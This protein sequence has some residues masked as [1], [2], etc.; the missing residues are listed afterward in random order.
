[1]KL[2]KKILATAMLLIGTASSAYAVNVTNGSTF[3]L[4]FTSTSFGGVLLDSIVTPVTTG[5]FSGLARAAVYDV[6]TGL[7]FYYQF[8]NDAASKHGIERLSTFNYADFTVWT[9]DAYQTN[10]AFGV[11]AAGTKAATTID[12]NI[13]GDVLGTNYLPAGLGKIEP[14]ENGYTVILRTNA[15]HYTT[16]NL[17]IIDGI[18]A[19]AP[20]FAPAVPE[21]ETYAM[22]I[23]G[24]GMLGFL[25][26]RKSAKN[27]G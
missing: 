26:R 20:A 10:A 4:P 6:G 23:A 1:M 24:L 21:P 11:F 12:R 22:M 27:L 18:S 25:A 5:V 16:G 15:H 13:Q 17:A 19:N 9:V 7:D 14:G 8:T 2:H 3:G